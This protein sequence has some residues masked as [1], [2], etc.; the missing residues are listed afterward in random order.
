MFNVT[1]NHVFLGITIRGYSLESPFIKV[2]TYSAELSLLFRNSVLKKPCRKKG[3]TSICRN[4]NYDFPSDYV[5]GEDNSSVQIQSSGIVNLSSTIHVNAPFD[6]QQGKII[7][8]SDIP[9]M[10]T[11]QNASLTSFPNLV[12][13]QDMQSVGTS[14]VSSE[15]K[16]TKTKNFQCTECGKHFETQWSLTRCGRMVVDDM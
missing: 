10:P 1:P 7:V 11:L 13:V 2:V 3:A 8:P 15:P 4:Q 14:K 12:M 16:R 5:S 6:N 9:N